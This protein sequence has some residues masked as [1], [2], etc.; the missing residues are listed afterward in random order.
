MEFIPDYLLKKY[1]HLS[2]G[3]LAER[4]YAIEENKRK[5]EL[6]QYLSSRKL[7]ILLKEKES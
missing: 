7:D 6:K 3:E 1:G 5:K 2:W 4:L